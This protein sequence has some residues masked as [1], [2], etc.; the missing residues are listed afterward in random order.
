MKPRTARDARGFTLVELLVVIAILSTLAGILLPVIGSM[1]GQGRQAAEVS[2]GR[3]IIAAY[4]A[5]AADNDGSLLPAYGN[6]PAA[7]DRGNALHNPVNARYAWR[8]APYLHYDIGV[9]YG[10]IGDD[11]LHADRRRDYDSWVY[12]VSVGPAFGINA[13]FVGG[14]YQGFSPEARKAVAAYGKFCV[15]RMSQAVQPARLIAFTTAAFEA[16]GGRVP[17]YFRVEAPSAVG[18]VWES[19]YQKGRSPDAYGHVDFRYG[20]RAIAVM[21]DGHVELLDFTQMDDMRRWSNQ[22]AELDLPNFTL[23]GN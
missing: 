16:P 9:L 19:A 15:T 12:A 5:Y 14:D 10:K 6:F 3:Q 2:A 7:D 4:T 23:G 1:R 11:R 17:G 21:L 22:A 18:R 13:R 8:L 20:D